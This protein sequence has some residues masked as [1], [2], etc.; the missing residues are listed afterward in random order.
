MFRNTNLWKIHLIISILAA[1]FR[2]TALHWT[3]L[4]PTSTKAYPVCTSV[5]SSPLLSLL[6]LSV[7]LSLQ[8]VEWCSSKIQTHLGTWDVTLFARKVFADI[9]KMRSS[10]SRKAFC[11]LAGTPESRGEAQTHRGEI[12]GIQP[13]ARGQPKPPETRRRKEGGTLEPSQGV[14]PCCSFTLYF[15]P[16]E[17]WE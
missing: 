5:P 16:L 4:W 12:E 6:C 11:S 15:W 9:I 17:C 7:L 3:H 13:W 10:V 1:H 2:G 8:Q 14:Q